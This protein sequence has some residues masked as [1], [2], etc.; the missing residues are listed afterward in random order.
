[1]HLA[2]AYCDQKPFMGSIIF[3]AT[4]K[5]QLKTIIN[6]LDTKLSTEVMN[7]LDKVHREFP[8]PI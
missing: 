7:E 1:M 5:E 3:G 4:T 6:G 8:F 2:L